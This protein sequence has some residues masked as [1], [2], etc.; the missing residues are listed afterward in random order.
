LRHLL[1]PDAVIVKFVG[2]LGVHD[3]RADFAVGAMARESGAAAVYVDPDAPSRLPLLVGRTSHL[4]DALTGYAAVILFAGGV[5]AAQEYTTLTSLRT[6][7]AS[8]ALTV[9]GLCEQGQS[10]TD[11]S[12]PEYDLLIPVAA[13]SARETRIMAALERRGG[14]RSPRVALVGNWPPGAAHLPGVVILPPMDPVALQT[15]YSRSRFTFN[16]LRSDFAGY[17]DTAAARIFE[18]AVSGSCIISEWFP[19]LPNYFEPELE[20]LIATG[21]RLLSALCVEEGDRAA[22]AQRARERVLA[23]AQATDRGL[24]RILAEL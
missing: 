5:R 11:G 9:L 18:A 23:D 6:H 21:E 14:D 20:C 16:P 17:S 8:P 13:Y 19:G 22:M 12:D 10:S 15:L 4:A 3:W 7:H 24:R 1:S 2:A